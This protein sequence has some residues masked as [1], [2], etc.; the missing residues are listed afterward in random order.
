[1]I[2]RNLKDTE[3]KKQ[4]TGKGCRLLVFLKKRVVILKLSKN[5]DRIK[6]NNRIVGGW[7][8]GK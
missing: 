3:N 2:R 4:V 8:R 1:M 6:M 5:C 7:L